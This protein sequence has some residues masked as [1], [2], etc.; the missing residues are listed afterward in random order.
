MGHDQRFKEFLQTFLQEFL[1]LFF[2]DVERRL[3]FR[4]IEF[5]DKEVFTNLV[6]GSSRRADVVAKLT[7][8]EGYEA[9]GSHDDP[10]A[11]H[12]Q[13]ETLDVFEFL[14]RVL[15]QNPQASPTRRPLH[16][17]LLLESARLSKIRPTLSGAT[18]EVPIAS[19]PSLPSR[20]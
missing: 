3:D 19:S 4:N 9:K 7:T 6:E 12:P 16:G 2:P 18:V 17:R 20:R 10:L 14:A 11:S 13:G 1:K 8:H 5:L 15:T